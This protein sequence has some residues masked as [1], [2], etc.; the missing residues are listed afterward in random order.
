MATHGDIERT[1]GIINTRTRDINIILNHWNQNQNDDTYRQDF[2]NHTNDIL[3]LFEEIVDIIDQT[4]QDVYLTLA[5]NIYS[6]LHWLLGNI[7]RMLGDPNDVTD[8]RHQVRSEIGLLD[9]TQR[10]TNMMN[11]L[12][13][14]IIRHTPREVIPPPPPPSSGGTRKCKH[15]K[16]RKTRKSR[17]IRKPKRKGKKTKRVR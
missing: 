9:K 16:V 15:K 17:K 10:M 4:P 12:D 14:Y 3:T 1:I 2:N 13:A 5:T 6:N 8:P 11:I 7:Y